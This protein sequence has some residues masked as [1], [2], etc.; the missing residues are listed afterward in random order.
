M[1]RWDSINSVGTVYAPTCLKCLAR[2]AYRV[3]SLEYHSEIYSNHCNKI[4]IDV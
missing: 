4:D 3:V 2:C 1:K